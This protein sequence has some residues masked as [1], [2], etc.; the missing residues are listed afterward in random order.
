ML[1]ARRVVL[2][3]SPMFS[4]LAVTL[5]VIGAPVEPTPAVSSA[6]QVQ[7]FMGGTVV[8]VGQLERVA[9]GKG[10]SEWQG[11]A[12]VL[13]DDTQIFVTYGA[14]P[15]GWEALVGAR[16]R[17]EGLLRPSLT[18]HEQSLL[19]PHLR[20]PGKPK[21]EERAL[22]KLLGARVRLSGVARDAKGGAVVLV[23]GSPWYLEGLATWPKEVHGKVVAVG[24]KL[25]DKQYLPQAMR[26][27]KGEVSQGAVG[28]Q[29][30]LEAPTW[31]LISEPTK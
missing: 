31:R 22:G 23:G 1:V 30:V 26:N 9:I 25:A 15:A 17:V 4:G 6:A 5:A 28:S 13:D 16:L 14:P 24:G 20:T 12:L 19:A 7:Q 2:H 18:D 21:K 8:V 27:E 10:K 11:T 29:N 3:S